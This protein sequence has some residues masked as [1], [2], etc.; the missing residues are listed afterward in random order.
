MEP[1]L[2]AKMLIRTGLV[3]STHFSVQIR[4][5][6]LKADLPLF[7]QNLRSLR[8]GR[9]LGGIANDSRGYMQNMQI[10]DLSC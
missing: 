10:L 2:D 1:R 5:H 6:Q 8:R 3:D 7:G 4:K 9:C